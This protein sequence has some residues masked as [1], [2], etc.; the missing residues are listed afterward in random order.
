MHALQQDIWTKTMTNIWLQCLLDIFCPLFG[1]GG[2]CLRGIGCIPIV[3]FQL[4]W[5][6][7]CTRAGLAFVQGSLPHPSTSFI[8]PQE[9]TTGGYRERSF[10]ASAPM[11]LAPFTPPLLAQAT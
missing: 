9:R 4:N 8:V 7:S 2:M 5:H 3:L 10:R 6:R 1:S 11:A